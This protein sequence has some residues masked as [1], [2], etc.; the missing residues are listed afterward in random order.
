M[1]AVSD[2]SG[3]SEPQSRRDRPAKALLNRGVI[4]DAALELVARD[5]LDGVTLRKVAQ[6]LDTGPASLYVYVANRDELLGRMLDR[7]LS[8]VEPVAVKH[9]RWRRRLLELFTAMLEALDRYP[10]IAHVALDSTATRPVAQ[11]I[12]ENATELLRAGGFDDQSAA[13]TRDALLL[14]TAATGVEHSVRAGGAEERHDDEDDLERFT[15]GLNALIR[16][17]RDSAPAV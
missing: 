5:G 14:F 1:P 8:E 15:F 10:G 12:A 3:L 2:V 16:G 17:A 7:V 11:A 9:K 4:V 6:R 13:W